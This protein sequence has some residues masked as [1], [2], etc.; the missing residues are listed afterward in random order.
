MWSA[1][2][3]RGGR[4]SGRRSTGGAHSSPATAVPAAARGLVVRF[5]TLFTLGAGVFMVFWT[6][7]Y[8]WLPEGLLRGAQPRRGACRRGPG[9][10]VPHCVAP[11]WSPGVAG[12]W[13]LGAPSRP[14]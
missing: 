10:L 1:P 13:G 11:R 7:A 2:E 3:V 12:M 9:A 5:M 4:W 14:P 8:L 6:V